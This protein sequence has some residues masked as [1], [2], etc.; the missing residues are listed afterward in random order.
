MKLRLALG[1]KKLGLGLDVT[2]CGTKKPAATLLC[3]GEHEQ[4]MQNL[5]NIISRTAHTPIVRMYVLI[6][7]NGNNCHFQS[8]PVLQTANV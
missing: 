8:N 4:V 6:K 1:V 2:A 5:F 3:V 7:K